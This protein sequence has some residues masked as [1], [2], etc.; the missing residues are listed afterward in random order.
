LKK[1]KGR[2]MNKDDRE[3]LIAQA[4]ALWRRR[5]QWDRPVHDEMLEFDLNM[6]MDEMLDVW[7]EK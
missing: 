6:E 3:R 2:K 5:D 7:K 4:I 1:R